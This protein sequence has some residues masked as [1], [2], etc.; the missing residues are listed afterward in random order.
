M[1][2]SLPVGKGSIVMTVVEEGKVSQQTALINE[3]GQPQ[4]GVFEGPIGDVNYRDHDLRNVMDK[5]RGRLARHFAFNQ[6]QF[7]SLCSEELIVGLAIVDLKWLS[8][9]FVYCFDP[10]TGDYEEFSF[11][12]PLSRN[13][14][15][16]TRPNDGR[17]SFRSGRNRLEISAKAGRRQLSVSLAAGLSIEADIDEHEHYQPMSICTRAGY[18]GWVYTQKTTARPLTGRVNWRGRE[19]DLEAIGALAGV[20]WSAGYMRRDTFW[21]WGSLSA[22]LADGRRLGFN[23]VAGVNDTGYTENAL[24][25]DDQM[26]KISTVVFEYDRQDHRAPWRMCSQDGILD[27]RFEPAGRRSEKRNAL[28]IA[29]NFTQYFGRFYGTVR[30]PDEVVELSGQWGFAEDHFAR[31]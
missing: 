8:N 15:F 25:I 12:A 29:S 17:A 5:P 20:D 28:L 7:L 19:R 14:T 31:W 1:G 4:F 30:L 13:T 11:L 24:W 10:L 18:A 27:L 21:N 2:A 26:V 3:N 6:F 16:D 23:L 9:A 22:R